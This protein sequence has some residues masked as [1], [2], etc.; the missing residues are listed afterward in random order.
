M[1]IIYCALFLFPLTAIGQTN[2]CSLLPE[3][4]P[5]FAAISKFYFDQTDGICKEFTW[6]GCD[7]VVPFHTM[8]ECQAECENPTNIL[9]LNNPVPK[10]FKVVDILGRE[11]TP[12]KNTLLFYHYEDGKVE[13]RYWVD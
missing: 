1:K 4:G 13:K 8:V 3:T 6:G 5:C 9:T 10:L 11:I 7:G 12:R 2:N